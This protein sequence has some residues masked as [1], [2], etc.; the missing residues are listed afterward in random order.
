MLRPPMMLPVS[1]FTTRR[2]SCWSYGVDRTRPRTFQWTSTYL[3]SPSLNALHTVP[4]P[5]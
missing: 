5:L 3:A 2:V 4:R 1:I